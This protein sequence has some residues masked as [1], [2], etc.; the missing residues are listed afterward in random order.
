MSYIQLHNNIN[1][2]LNNQYINDNSKYGSEIY[3]NIKNEY[4]NIL[5]NCNKLNV[6]CIKNNIMNYLLCDETKFIATIEQIR[7]IN[8]NNIMIHNNNIYYNNNIYRKI[9]NN[10]TIISPY[11]LRINDN[12]DI[13]NI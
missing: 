5:E 10:Y 3:S 11:F 12:N 6:D 9:T 7:L 13:I 4:K 2:L 8:Q 1:E